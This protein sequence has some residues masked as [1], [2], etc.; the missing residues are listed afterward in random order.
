M[1]TTGD[2]EALAPAIRECLAALDPD[3]GIESFM[4]LTDRI[5]TRLVPYRFNMLL[6]SAFAG[7]ALL[8][9]AGGI[10]GVLA[11]RVSRRTHEIGLRKALGADDVAIA[12]LV[13]RHGLGP[14]AVGLAVG[15]G[16]SL[17]LTRLLEGML[18]GV[19]PTDQLTFAAV[20][21][22]LA[23]VS[24]LACWMPARRAARLDPMQ[25]MRVD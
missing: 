4:T 17:A 24:V 21:A 23:I 9:A 8:L 15:I 7:L 18:Y 3:L 6:L 11:Y 22:L 1:R 19:E 14:A 5:G 13:L 25:A 20:A 16:G 12:R 10:Y 2:P